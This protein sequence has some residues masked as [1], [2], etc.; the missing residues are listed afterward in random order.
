MII[1]GWK[2]TSGGDNGQYLYIERDG[3]PGTVH[4]KADDEGFSIDVWSADNTPEIVA[5]T[6][7][8]YTALEPE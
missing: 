1:N 7:A 8:E 4:I 6:C 3:A 2:V 5:S